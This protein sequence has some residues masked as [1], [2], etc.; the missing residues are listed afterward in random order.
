MARFEGLSEKKAF[1]LRLEE[2]EEE[3]DGW[4]HRAIRAEAE[5]DRLID[6]LGDIHA[7][8]ECDR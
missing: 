4:R 8:V 3:R 5:R 2:L 6:I 1:S 7:L